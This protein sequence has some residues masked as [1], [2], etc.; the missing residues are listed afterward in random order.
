MQVLGATYRG[1]ARAANVL[2]SLM[3]TLPRN[4]HSE[5]SVSNGKPT[6]PPPLG[7]GSAAMLSK[8]AA[9]LVAKYKDGTSVL[10]EAAEDSGRAESLIKGTR[11][12]TTLIAAIIVD[13]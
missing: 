7:P 13:E 5:A 4:A 11:V 10:E 1:T 6:E 9:I 3:D 8:L 12:W 2:A